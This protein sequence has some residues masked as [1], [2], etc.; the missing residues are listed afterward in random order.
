MKR[1]ATYFLLISAFF[2]FTLSCQKQPTSFDIV[3]QW[4]VT[5]AIYYHENADPTRLT[6]SNNYYSQYW[7][8]QINGALIITNHE[9]TKTEY[10]DY[11]YN[12]NT[13]NLRY[14][15][16]DNIYKDY[17]DA[18]VTIYSPTE[19]LITTHNYTGDSAIKLK[20]LKW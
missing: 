4:G 13:R 6:F 15:L 3:G 17:R 5:E 20:K 12:T 9:G 1:F 7:T 16:P 8:F 19:I 2:I 10:G 18:D 14:R 11:I